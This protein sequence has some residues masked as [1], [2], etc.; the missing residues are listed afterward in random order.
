MSQI[1]QESWGFR[2]AELPCDLHLTEYL[3]E[4]Q[5]TDRTI[6]H[7]GTGD[8]HHVGITQ[9]EGVARNSVIGITASTGEYQS[10]INLVIRKPEIAQWYQVSFGD[11]YRINRQLL[12]ALDVVSLFHLCEFSP[13]A[14]SKGALS[15]AQVLAVMTDCLRPGGLVIFYPRSHAWAKT[16]PI[17]EAWSRQAGIEKLEDYKSLLVYRKNAHVG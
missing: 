4:R 6:Y 12:P 8:H 10:Y 2:V 5:L 14:D 17:V 3:A 16:G 15:D 1:W 9:A 7:F 13:E 11:I